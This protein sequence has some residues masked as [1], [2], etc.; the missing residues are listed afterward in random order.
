MGRKASFRLPLRACL[1]RIRV[2]FRGP[3]KLAFRGD[4]RQSQR[5]SLGGAEFSQFFESTPS[6]ESYR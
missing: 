2:G 6:E 1:V 3:E 5:L 4:R